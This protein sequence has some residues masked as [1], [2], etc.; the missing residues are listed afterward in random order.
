[1]TDRQF[2]YFRIGDFVAF[3]RVFSKDEMTAFSGLSGDENPL[4]WDPKYAALTE[5]KKPI[6]PAQLVAS[7]LSAIA[8]MML[9]G[10]RS[11]YLGSD[12]KM[13]SPA[14]FGDK[15]TYSA[16]VNGLSEAGSVLL[17]DVT[18]FRKHDLVLQARLKVKVR[19]DVDEQ[20]APAH[21]DDVVIEKDADSNTA[22]VTGAGG[23]VGSSVALELIENGWDVILVFRK[24]SARIKKL[25][26]AA[27]DAGVKGSLA[28][29][30]L[31][32]E[33]ELTALAKRL[34]RR[35]DIRLLVHTASPP[36]DA[37]LE[38]HMRV[39]FTALQSLTQA[40]LPGMLRRQ[41]GRIIQVGS[42]AI[43]FQPAGWE[44]YIAAKTAAAGFVDS[45]STRFGSCGI[46]GVTIS[47]GFIDTPFSSKVRSS[48][49]VPLLAEEVAELVGQVAGLDAH[50]AAQTTY[51]WME[52]GRTRW[53]RFGFSDSVALSAQAD[54][55]DVQAVPDKSET[56][57]V[58]ARQPVG[59]DSVAVRL[60]A[61]L[62][63]RFDIAGDLPASEI[64]MHRVSGWDS[65]HHLELMLEIEQAFGIQFSAHDMSEGA[66]FA[67]LNTLI[68]AKLGS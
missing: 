57:T 64:D 16:R 48:G 3:D 22:V 35:K 44:N 27:K 9:P 31:A 59:A 2:D 51:I 49:R 43:Q 40:L 26:K 19:S 38:N 17:I 29:A 14:Y 32:K 58:V 62:E 1:M 24:E 54:T 60:R 12:M 37:S 41:S 5:F 18:V 63:Q 11:L 23:Q 7:P 15:L 46:A 4:H 52:P 8:G 47:P 67:E 25:E 10:H 45:I 53:G 42:S 55:A 33:P 30:N 68:L 20:H 28:K 61:I 21:D 13:L 50:A 36:I 6:I 56:D 66:N 39:N 65:F 34:S